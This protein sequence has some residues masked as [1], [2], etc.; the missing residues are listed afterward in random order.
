MVLVGEGGEGDADMNMCREENPRVVVCL[1]KI[2]ADTSVGKRS[3]G[4]HHQHLHQQDHQHACSLMDLARRSV[5]AASRGHR[6]IM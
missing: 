6:G 2:M 3:V 1:W 4:R 5:V